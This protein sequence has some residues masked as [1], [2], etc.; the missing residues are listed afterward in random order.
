M[1]NVLIHTV[2]PNVQIISPVSLL[3]AILVANRALHPGESWFTRYRIYF[4]NDEA[5]AAYTIEPPHRYAMLISSFDDALRWLPP[6]AAKE[7]FGYDRRARAYY[8]PHC[9]RDG[10]NDWMIE[11]HLGQ[12]AFLQ[13]KTKQSTTLRCAICERTSPVVR[14]ACAA[15]NC[16]ATVI[17]ADADMGRMCLFCK[18]DQD[19]WEADQKEDEA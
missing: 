11:W 14:H 18:A 16:N 9:L 6:D 17:A 19:E 2:A 10:D 12:T 3:H 15:D 8:C 1:R 5:Q 4:E 13:P 7:F